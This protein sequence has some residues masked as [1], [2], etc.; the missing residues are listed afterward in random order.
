M[1]LEGTN[2]RSNTIP[3][4]IVGGV[5]EGDRIERCHGY[6]LAQF[7]DPFPQGPIKEGFDQISALVVFC[8]PGI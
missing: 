4:L 3:E 1:L 7:N 6:F 2:F 5:Y 8:V